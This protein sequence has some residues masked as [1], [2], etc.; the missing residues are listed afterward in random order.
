M[1]HFR[2]IKQ[3]RRS[4][5]NNGY[6]ITLNESLE[7]HAIKRAGTRYGLLLTHDKVQG[8]I[9]HVILGNCEYIRY[10]RE[11]RYEYSAVVL[12]ELTKEFVEVRFVFD[13][14]QQALVT[15]LYF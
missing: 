13:F 7:R 6:N 3:R 12:N 14:K 15:F 8:I 11:E 4:R 10:Q 1:G 2:K 5:K 9:Q